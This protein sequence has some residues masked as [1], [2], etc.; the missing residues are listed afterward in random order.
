MKIVLILTQPF[1]PS[2]GGVQ[3]STFKMGRYFSR[4]GHEVW[5]YSMAHNGHVQPVDGI[6]YHAPAPGGSSDR[7]N[8]EDLFT[9]LVRTRPDVV[10]NQMVYEQPITDVLVRAREN[11]AFL[12]LGVLRNS[13]LNFDLDVRHRMTFM[14][15]SWLFSL[16]DHPLG[17]W[18]VRMRHRIRHRREL[19]YILDRYDRLVLLTPPNIDELKV[20][21]GTYR[22]DKV[23]FVPNSVLEVREGSD[24]PK[25]KIILYVGR[26]NREQKRVDLLV[27]IWQQAYGNLPEWRFVVV[28]DGPERKAMDQRIQT[29][30]IPRMA[31]VGHQHPE[32]WYQRAMIFVMTSGFE[33][34]P[35]VLIEAQSHGAVPVAFNSYPALPWIVHGGVDA[36]LVPA[37]DT[38]AMGSALV[39]LAHD[40]DLLERMRIAALDNS[41]RFTLDKVGRQ[42]L[43]LIEEVRS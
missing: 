43:D 6:L 20:F 13:L 22:N 23:S 35:N 1:S 11:Q 36:V 41:S 27:D 5:Y 40:P 19:R 25:E 2:Q 34:F 12:C 18:M 3:R 26:L 31:L 17:V 24:L 16:L 33:G 10:I 9:I 30:G 21:V 14:L 28:G 8:Q 29:V 42:W 38:R 15:P 39:E 37:F 4:Q 32:D 7:Q